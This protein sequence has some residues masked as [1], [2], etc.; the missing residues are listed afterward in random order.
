MTYI[1][2]YIEGSATADDIENYIEYWHTHE[3]GKPLHEFLGLTW[4]EYGQWL[5]NGNDESLEAIVGSRKLG[6]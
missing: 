5:R 6:K 3:T 4:E 1:D 2:K